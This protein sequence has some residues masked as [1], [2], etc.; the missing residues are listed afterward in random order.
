MEVL[1]LCL[2]TQTQIIMVLLKMNLKEKYKKTNCSSFTLFIMSSS[3]Y[4][5]ITLSAISFKPK[6]WV[7]NRNVD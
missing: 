2:H 7:R 5:T 6:K 1:N 3:E 4:K